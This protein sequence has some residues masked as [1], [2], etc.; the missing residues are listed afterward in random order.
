MAKLPTIT[1]KIAPDLRRFLDRMREV[2]EGRNP[3]VTQDDLVQSG[4]HQKRPDGSL[5]G[6]T[7]RPSCGFPPAPKNLKARGAMTS[8]LLS[9]DDSGWINTPCHAF[10]Q[11]YRADVDD[12]SKAA[13]I[14]TSNGRLYSDAVGTAAKH[15][16]WVRFLSTEDAIGPLNQTNGVLG[17]TAQDV[18]Y[19]MDQLAGVFGDDSSS[20]FFHLPEP[21][22]NPNKPGE[23][24]PAGTYLRDGFIHKAQITDAMI[25]DLAVDKLTVTEDST[26]AKALIGVGDI[27]DAMIG[28]EIKGKQGQWRI[29]KNGAITARSFYLLDNDNKVLFG[30]A[31][32]VM[33][34][35]SSDNVDGLG[36]FAALSKLDKDNI[37]TFIAGA[38]ISYAYIGND[39]QSANYRAAES[40]KPPEGWRLDREGK[41]VLRDAEF[42]GEINVRSGTDRDGMRIT[43][44]AVTVLQG[45][46]ER[47][48]IG[49]LL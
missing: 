9:W 45:G 49:K 32:G 33:R 13:L 12:F 7:P 5:I 14:G 4:T 27:Q 20:P 30:V 48:R 10:T 16:Y 1:S 38:A 15:Y 24:I 40:G 19:L 29:D 31:D 42:Y 6:L 41:M 11:V 2:F 23:L 25:A 43:N 34:K 47:V 17:Q 22:E 44:E 39:I 18:A 46:V 28:N 26:F 21:M 8:I 36:K 3:V 35:L 37:S